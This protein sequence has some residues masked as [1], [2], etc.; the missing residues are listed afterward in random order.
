MK[1][2]PFAYHAPH[3]TDQVLELLAEYGDEAKV[4]AGGQSLIPLLNFRLARPAIVIDVTRVP[5]LSYLAE[6]DGS[7]LIGAATRQAAL[8]R[9][10]LAAQGWP[11]LVEA[12]Q[13]VAHPQIRNLGTV[14][15]SAAHA[16]PAAELPAVF[17]TLDARFHLRSTRDVRT[18]TADQFFVGYFTTALEPDELLVEIEV[19]PIPEGTGYAFVEFARRHGDFALGGAA[20]LMVLDAGG[21]CRRVA[22]TLLGAETPWRSPRT[23]QALVGRRPD[24]TSL[25]AAATA[26]VQG[27]APSGDIHGSAEYRTALAEVIARR[28]LEPLPPTNCIMMLSD[29]TCVEHSGA[30]APG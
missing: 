2:A 6:R 23:E 3:E 22:L 5:A 21:V 12:L 8:E 24:E 1:P 28:A 16:D 26:A 17:T 9:S 10:P 11:I 14:G 18:L 29:Y 19:P 7:L 20:A 15:G 25:A 30:C 4:L 27:F 13:H